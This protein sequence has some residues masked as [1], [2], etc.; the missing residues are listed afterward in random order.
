VSFLNNVS[1]NENFF[2]DCNEGVSIG[3]DVS[4]AHTS[5]F[6]S[7]NHTWLDKDMPIKYNPM[8]KKGIT[9]HNDVWIGCGVRVLDGVTIYYRCVF[10]A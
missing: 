10:E 6:V 1:I 3:K 4:I 2:I 8:T 9:I 5:S 7:A